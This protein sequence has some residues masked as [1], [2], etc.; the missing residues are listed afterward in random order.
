[1]NASEPTQFTFWSINARHR[2][3]DIDLD[4]F[5]PRPFAAIADIERDRE[6]LT[7]RHRFTRWRHIPIFV[8][9]VAEPEAKR[10]ERL[11]AR[12]NI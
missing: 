6:F 9:G 8:G 11:Y 1:M 5:G 4:I 2:V 12:R 10:K 3:M 7:G